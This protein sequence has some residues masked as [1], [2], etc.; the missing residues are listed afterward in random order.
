MIKKYNFVMNEYYVI[1]TYNRGSISGRIRYIGKY[2]VS[3]DNIAISY[4]DIAVI[5]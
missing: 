2:G 5:I 1:N 3:L 4:K